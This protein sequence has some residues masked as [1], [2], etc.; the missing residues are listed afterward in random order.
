APRK[1][2][3]EGNEIRIQRKIPIEVKKRIIA[4]HEQNM[5]IKDIASHYNMPR[6]TISTI[7]KNKEAIKSTKSKET[8]KSRELPPKA[9]ASEPSPSTSSSHG[10]KRP[11]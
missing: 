7:I 3:D 5:R 10:I 11:A 6:S 9:T 1:A 8:D 2:N 4:K